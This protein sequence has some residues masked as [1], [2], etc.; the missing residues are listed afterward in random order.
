MPSSAHTR[1]TP[2]HR[3]RRRAARALLGLAAAALP[4]LTA[5]P[6][7]AASGADWDRL[8]SC[9]SGGNWS[10]NTG[11]GYYGGLQFSSGT[12]LGFG[13]G[14]YASRADLASRDQQIA[15]ASKVLAVQGWN[16][17]PSCSRKLGLYGVSTAPTPPP[18]PPAPL[19][20]GAIAQRYA[21]LGGAGSALGAPLGPEAGSIRG[22]RYNIFQRGAIY[23]TPARGAWEVHGAVRGAWQS[24]GSEFSY[25]GYPVTNELAT[26]RRYGAANA[27]EGG[28]IYWSPG[29][30]AHAVRGGILQAWAA[31]GLE[32]GP[33]GFPTASERATAGSGGAIGRF[34]G[35]AV[36]WSPST[37]THV[38]RGGIG[39][40]WIAL[41]ADASP[42]GLPTSDEFAVQNGRR[43]TFQNGSITWSPSRAPQVRLK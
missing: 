9:E 1:P 32:N 27:F 7:S 24:M 17:W 30:G 35:G 37:G 11:N 21:S 43:T 25:L 29:T 36:T 34:E 19:V 14:A 6:A 4:F 16:A 38:V 23:W 10:I 15:I 5:G 18:P 39:E 2:A 41:G 20:V 3:P 12:W 28:W 42:L 33:L 26:P 40:T 13:G 22:A 31:S 8:A